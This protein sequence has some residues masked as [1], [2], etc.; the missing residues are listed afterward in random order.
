M[1][2]RDIFFDKGPS[3]YMMPEVFDNYFSIFNKKTS[4]F[5]QLKK[6]KIHYKVFFDAEENCIITNNPKANAKIFEQMEKGAAYKLQEYLS[7]SKYIYDKAIKDLVML[8]YSSLSQ[9]LNLRILYYLFR[10]KF[11]Y[12]ST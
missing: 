10:F 2:K 3:W 6:L 8:D 4:D 5:Y 12:Q 1:S 9:I 11:F 7:E